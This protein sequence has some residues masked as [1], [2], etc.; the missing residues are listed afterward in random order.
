MVAVL[1]TLGAFAASFGIFALDEADGIVEDECFG[2]EVEVLD[3]GKVRLIGWEG[4][5]ATMKWM[6]CVHQYQ[7]TSGAYCITL[8]QCQCYRQA[9]PEPQLSHSQRTGLG[10]GRVTPTPK[11]LPY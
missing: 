1:G 9:P 10:Q 5:E 6:Q 2:L 7:I 8:E 11:R 3:C 4:S